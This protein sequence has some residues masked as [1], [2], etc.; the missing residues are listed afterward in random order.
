MTHRETIEKACQEHGFPIQEWVETD[1]G[2]EAVLGRAVVT[3]DGDPDI[4]PFAGDSGTLTC[5]TVG[6]ASYGNMRPAFF[7]HVDKMDPAEVDALSVE[8]V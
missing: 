8:P 1:D 2:P 6:V 7:L 5:M 3:T 4:G